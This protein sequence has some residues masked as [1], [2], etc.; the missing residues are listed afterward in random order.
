VT[1][2]RLS[3]AELLSIIDSLEEDTKTPSE[4]TP[5]FEGKKTGDPLGKAQCSF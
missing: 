5:A 3:K 4:V 2:P 1:K